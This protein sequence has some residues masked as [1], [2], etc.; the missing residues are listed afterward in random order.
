MA[1]LAEGPQVEALYPQGW[2]HLRL[3]TEGLLDRIS[4]SSRVFRTDSQGSGGPAGLTL[5]SVPKAYGGAED[6]IPALRG[7]KSCSHKWLRPSVAPA[8]GGAAREAGEPERWGLGVAPGA[9][10]WRTQG[11][12]GRLPVG[13]ERPR[14]SDLELRT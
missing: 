12:L 6:A 8:W 9:T 10:G 1:G 4:T 2:L 7:G 11:G 5:P 3:V 14:K 13:G